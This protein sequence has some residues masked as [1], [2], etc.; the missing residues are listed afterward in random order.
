MVYS[1]RQLDEQV[2]ATA[3]HIFQQVKIVYRLDDHTITKN[4]L[5]LPCAF[6]IASFKTITSKL[7]MNNYIIVG[8]S[9]NGKLAVM[10]W[11]YEQI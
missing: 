11:Q 6:F 10:W 4:L 9:T 8:D 1:V 3:P 5:V 2:L 7:C